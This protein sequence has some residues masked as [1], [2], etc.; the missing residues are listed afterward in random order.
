MVLGSIVVDLM[1][2]NGSVNDRRLNGFLIYN[3]LDGLGEASQYVIKQEAGMS[4]HLMDVMVDM[5]ASHGGQ[6]RMALL[7][8]CFGACA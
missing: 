7:R 6:G 3:R 1:N 8:S 4:T 2:G 5:F